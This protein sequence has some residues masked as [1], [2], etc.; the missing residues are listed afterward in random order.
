MTNLGRGVFA[1]FDNR[2]AGLYSK[3]TFYY[4]SKRIVEHV[5]TLLLISGCLVFLFPCTAL[6]A[7]ETGLAL[8]TLALPLLV[9]F[10]VAVV[11]GWLYRQ[12]STLK[13]QHSDLVVRN[14]ILSEMVAQA[15]WPLI[16]IDKQLKI[17]YANREAKEGFGSQTLVGSS[18]P[19]LFPDKAAH[20]LLQILQSDEQGD[21]AVPASQSVG[22]ATLRLVTIDGKLFGLWYGPPRREDCLQSSEDFLDQAEESANRMK[23]EFIA[24]INHEVRTPMNAII[25]YT[26]MLVNSPIGAKEKR[27]VETIHKSSMA[28][29]SIFNDIMELSKI[30]SGRL[31]I[32]TSS[33]RMDS[34]IREV[35]GLYRDQALEKGIR[36]ECRLENHLPKSFILDGMRLKQVLHNLVSNAIKFTNDGHVLVLVDGVPSKEKDNCYDLSIT[37]EDT[38][39]GIPKT[40]QQKIF[41]VFSQR[42]DTIAKRY[43]GVGLGLTLCSRLVTM[44]GGRID[45]VSTPGEGASF[46]VLFDHIPLAEP[47]SEQFTEPDAPKGKNL[48][49]AL[50]MLVVD[51][52]DLIKDVFTDFFQDGPHKVLTANTGEEAL[53]L[54]RDEHPDIIFMDLNLSGMDGRS[55]TE[56]IRAEEALSAIPVIVMTGEILEEEDYKPLF[57]GFLQKP[58]RLEHLMDVI[59][60]YS[61]MDAEK[62][63]QADL[64]GSDYEGAEHAFF[65]S[66]QAAWN[67]ELDHLL[68]QAVR[69]GSLADAAALGAAVGKEGEARKDTVL[70]TFGGD[71]LK[72]AA[73]PNIMGVDRLLAQFSRVVNRKD[74]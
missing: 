61:S 20:P 38:G 11:A 26:E 42:E 67:D 10:L 29:V 66:V 24:N 52:V 48:T 40:D 55:V 17:V 12:L 1:I 5:H 9:L 35:E 72:F 70:I 53:V 8:S 4:S 56:K 31:Q 27:F 68:R 23:S 47:S 2:F 34:L 19:E 71:L 49:R 22:G 6:A 58:F 46:T 25:G 28:L 69:S 63:P 18:F 60:Q 36:F 59:G 65:K 43:G 37:V 50:T 54:A 16:Q 14:Q 51:D 7:Q 33:I 57:D 73:E 62:S 74:V 13:K 30:D 44:M 21:I 45:L 41:K 15:P 32:M 39:I 3:Q 64:D